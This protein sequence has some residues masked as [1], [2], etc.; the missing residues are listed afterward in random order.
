[1]S[2]SIKLLSVITLLGILFAAAPR[3]AFACSCVSQGDPLRASTDA[4]AI[5]V[6][7]VE[8]LSPSSVLFRGGANFNVTM[9]WK[10][11]ETSRLTL[12]YTGSMCDYRFEVGREYLV[13]AYND[14]A[15]FHADSCGRTMLVSHAQ[16]NGEFNRLG[17]GKTIIPTPESTNW[18]AYLAVIVGPLSLVTLA[19]VLVRRKH[20]KQ[21][22]A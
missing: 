5:F 18:P 12:T 20:H 3:R 13:Y 22:T 4:D 6:G 15:G 9:A 19:V 2:R 16:A 14:N 17:V 7:K 8:A 1:M 21:L 10:G 11:I